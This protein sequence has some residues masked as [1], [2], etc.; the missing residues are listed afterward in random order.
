VRDLAREVLEGSGYT[1]LQACDAQD[2]VFMVEQ[3]R[4]PIH[5]LLT[6]VIM[7]KQ[8]GRALVERLR[9]LRPGTSVR[10]ALDQPARPA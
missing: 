7:P 5:L 4:G 2:A 10:V 1:V 8:S 9:P 3:H 6:D